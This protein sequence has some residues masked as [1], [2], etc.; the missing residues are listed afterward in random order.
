MIGRNA[1]PPADVGKRAELA[2][3]SGTASDYSGFTA[4][5][6][7]STATTRHLPCLRSRTVGR[8]EILQSVWDQAPMP[9]LQHSISGK[10]LLSQLRRSLEVIEVPKNQWMVLAKSL[11][12]RAS[13]RFLRICRILVLHLS[14]AP[15]SPIGRCEC[16]V[17]NPGRSIS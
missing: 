3:T 6:S 7:P 14:S 8:L 4:F 5:S 2:R 13:A 11:T 15:P 9:Y 17:D 1:R 12:V 16:S 10:E